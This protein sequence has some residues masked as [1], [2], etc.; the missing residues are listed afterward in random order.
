MSLDGKS[1]GK[2]REGRGINHVMMVTTFRRLLTDFDRRQYSFDFSSKSTRV[3]KKNLPLLLLAIRL[4]FS[5]LIAFGNLERLRKAVHLQQT[6]ISAISADA[7]FHFIL[8]Q[9]L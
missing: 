3:T 5:G 8:F 2:T 7:S 4:R 9:D 6:G 1:S